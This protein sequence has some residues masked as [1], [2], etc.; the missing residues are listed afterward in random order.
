M[1]MDDNVSAVGTCSP[2]RAHIVGHGYSRSK[3]KIA[4][5]PDSDGAVHLIEEV[6]TFVSGRKMCIIFCINS[7]IAQD[8]PTDLI[9]ASVTCA[10]MNLDVGFRCR[11]RGRHLRA[12]Y[13]DTVKT[14]STY[15]RAPFRESNI[16]RWRGKP[17][18]AESF[19][20]ASAE[21]AFINKCAADFSSI[22]QGD[23]I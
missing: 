6:L 1:A 10:R 4:A 16:L 11:L 18:P 5:M 7:Y 20:M 2:N 23:S 12:L 22:I 15:S 8:R 17:F 19:G 9:I 13:Y 21:G 3:P 14:G